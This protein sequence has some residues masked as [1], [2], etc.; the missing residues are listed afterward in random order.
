MASKRTTNSDSKTRAAQLS[1]VGT[2]PDTRTATEKRKANMVKAQ[3]RRQEERERRQAE[4]G[5]APSNLERYR[6][7]EYPVSE[8]TDREVQK[9]RPEGRDGFAGPFPSLTG[10]QHSEIKRELLK[11]GQRRID[12]LYG[13]AIRTLADIARNGENES[14]RVKA[15]QELLNRT[16]GKTPERIEIKSSD[17]WQDILDDIMNDD[18]LERVQAEQ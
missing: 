13:T 1:L 17:P 9:G 18:V 6:A 8:W 10:K 12:A 3:A 2:Q 4:R 7:G 5:D 15:A 16:A 14:A 11:R